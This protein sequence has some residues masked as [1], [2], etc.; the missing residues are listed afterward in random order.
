MKRYAVI[1]NK[2]PREI[3]LLLGSGCRY[4]LCSF[5]DYHLDSSNDKAICFSTNKKALDMVDGRYQ[6][7]EV[8]N[9]GSFIDLDENTIEYIIKTCI[10]NNIKLLHFECHY[11]YKNAIAHFKKRFKKH[12]IMLKIKV[13]VESF[14]YDFRENILKKGINEK[15]PM[16]IA[17]DFDEVCLL[18]GLTGQTVESMTADIEIGLKYFERVCVNI[19]NKNT[20]DIQPN[21]EVIALFKNEVMPIYINNPRVDILLDNTDFGV[22]E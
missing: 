6:H 11:I 7:L 8:I 2:N 9:S 10:N 21:N 5:C 16:L 3:V 13:G 19:M 18:Q 20:T 4:K 22:G 1:E 12:G 14:D 17:K 15:K